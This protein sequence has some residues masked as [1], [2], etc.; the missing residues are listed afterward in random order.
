MVP[1]PGA[2]ILLIGIHIANIL[3]AFAAGVAG[4]AAPVGIV[5]GLVG[6]AIL[7]APDPVGGDLDLVRSDRPGLRVLFAETRL[8]ATG[9]AR[10]RRGRI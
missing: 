9:F 10:P 4:S 3:A 7:F 1:Q 6:N 5:L 8:P 2:W